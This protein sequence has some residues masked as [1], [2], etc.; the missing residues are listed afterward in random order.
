M[1]TKQGD[2]TLASVGEGSEA[3]AL[4][5]NDSIDSIDELDITHEEFVGLL[6]QAT[7]HSLKFDK[8]SGKVMTIP[9]IQTDKKVG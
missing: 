6:H 3:Y 4:R 5:E 8:I 9:K 1:T 7:T 2:T